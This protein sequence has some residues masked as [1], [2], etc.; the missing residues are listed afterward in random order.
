MSRPFVFIV[1]LCLSAPALAAELPKSG[2]FDTPTGW[3]AVGETM[4]VGGLTLSH[5]VYWGILAYQS[6]HVSLRQRANR[7]HNHREGEMC[8]EGSDIHRVHG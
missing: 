8:M 1:A 2:N 3:K 6:R 7:R 4:Q 5:G